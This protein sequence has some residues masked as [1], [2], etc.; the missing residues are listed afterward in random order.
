M[1][2]LPLQQAGRQGIQHRRAGKLGNKQRHGKNQAMK[3]RLRHGM[4][5]LFKGCGGEEGS[6]RLDNA[7]FEVTCVNTIDT[8]RIYML[9]IHK[10]LMLMLMLVWM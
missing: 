10:M 9:L 8:V 2:R 6:A 1:G 7:C 4:A 5:F 3:L